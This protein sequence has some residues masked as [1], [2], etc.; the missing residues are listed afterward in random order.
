MKIR[1]VRIKVPNDIYEMGATL[2][3]NER[4][5]ERASEHACKASERASETALTTSPMS[6]TMPE[7]IYKRLDREMCTYSWPPL[8]YSYHQYWFVLPSWTVRYN[9]D[10]GPR[11]A[12]V[13]GT[14]MIPPSVSSDL[15]RATTT[16]VRP[17]VDHLKF[18]GW[19][20]RFA[21]RVWSAHYFT[22]DLRE[23][24]RT[25]LSRYA[26]LARDDIEGYR[27]GNSSVGDSNG[28]MPLI[29]LHFR[30]RSRVLCVYQRL[31]V[32]PHVD[33]RTCCLDSSRGRINEKW[34]K[35]NGTL[36]RHVYAYFCTSLSTACA[37]TR[38][39]HVHG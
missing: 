17:V 22:R 7:M 8:Q 11:F 10:N 38:V 15:R 13:L 39:H 16:L 6:T 34:R 23:C 19:T 2:G 31:R 20:R 27:T 36:V 37:R 29:W 33:P 4:T 24:H 14:T 30:R 26:R 28:A 18:I 3:S 1:Y 12:F 25:T 5:S 35:L 9:I 21:P 32:W